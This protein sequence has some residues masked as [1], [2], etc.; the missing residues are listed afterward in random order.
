MTVAN[1]LLLQ[2]LPVEGG[3]VQPDVGAATGPP[4]WVITSVLS[5]FCGTVARAPGADTGAEVCPP[6]VVD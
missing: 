1:I 2:R 5:V 4:C 6:P 3:H